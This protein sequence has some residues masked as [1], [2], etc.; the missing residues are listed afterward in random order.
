VTDYHFNVEGINTDDW[1]LQIIAAKIYYGF[2]TSPKTASFK[3]MGISSGSF[4]YIVS[5]DRDLTPEEETILN[6][7]MAQSDVGR[8]PTSG[9]W[10]KIT[11]PCLTD[12]WELVEEAGTLD[13]AFACFDNITAQYVMFIKEDTTSTKKAT[14]RQALK[15]TIAITRVN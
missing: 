14:I 8:L 7:V 11:M 9:G 2:D 12:A 1:Q 6:G 10:T 4:E 5:I 15:D 13:V 3:I